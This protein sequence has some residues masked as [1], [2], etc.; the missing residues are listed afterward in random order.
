MVKVLKNGLFKFILGV[1][2][3]VFWI[4]VFG[5]IF[6]MLVVF[7]VLGSLLGLGGWKVDIL[8]I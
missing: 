4:G 6:G 8:E 1:I 3:K 5:I 2:L 7:K